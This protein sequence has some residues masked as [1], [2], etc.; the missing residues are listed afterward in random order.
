MEGF[1]GI[2]VSFLIWAGTH[3]K[4]KFRLLSMRVLII[5]IILLNR[6]FLTE[7]DH[8]I[9]IRTLRLSEKITKLELS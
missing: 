6:F 2:Y 8:P 5:L 9:A 7:I 3:S 1:F 4:I